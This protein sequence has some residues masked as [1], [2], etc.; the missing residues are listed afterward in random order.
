MIQPKAVHILIP[1]T[2]VC[3]TNLNTFQIHEH[4]YKTTILISKVA[5]LP[6]HSNTAA[7]LLK[8]PL[9]HL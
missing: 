5:V 8:P 1:K 9:V 2:N 7:F 4:T 3:D 6:N